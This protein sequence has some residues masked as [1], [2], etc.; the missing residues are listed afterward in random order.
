MLFIG[1]TLLGYISYSQLPVELLP[2]AEVPFLIVMV[3]STIDVDPDYLEKEAIIPLEGAVSTLEGIDEI[4]STIQSQRGTIYV[5][6]NQNVEIKY[7]YL[8]LQERV[9]EIKS[10]IS[11]EF[12][13]N[14]VK[15]D[16]ERLSNQFMTLQVRGSG[17]QERIRSIVDEK[18]SPELQSIDG[19]ANVEI[20]GGNV[21]ALEIILDE[22]A[23]SQYNITPARIRSLISQNTQSKTF[24]GW[25]GENDRRY[26]V[27]LLTEYTDVSNIEDI[28][29]VP[30]GPILL[31]DIA[32]INFG[33][34]EQESISRVNGM[35]AVSIS[36]VRDSQTNLIELSHTTVVRISELNERLA[37]Q[38]IEIVIQTN[39]AADV[40]ENINLIIELALIGGA[41]A[42]V[43]L[44]FFLRNLRLVLIMMLAIP[45]SVFT[46]FNFF[47][48][49][50][51]SLNSFTLVG[52][53]L[54]VG[55]LLDNSVVVLENIYRLVENRKDSDTAVIQGTREVWRAILAATLTTITVFLPFVF[56]TNYLVRLIGRHVGVSIISTLLVS[57]VVALLLVPM[58]THFFLK[59]RPRERSFKF[60]RISQRN[61]L[62]QIYTLLLKT[63]MR[64]PAQTIIG[65]VVAF[66]AS[67]LICMSLSMTVP[68]EIDL[69]EFNL[70]VTMS[71]GSTLEMT[72]TIVADFEEKISGIE[73][74]KDIVCTI[75]D[76][77]ANIT[78]ILKDDFESIANRTIAQIKNEI[79]EQAD[80][81]RAADISMSE[82]QSS[83]RFGGGMRSNPMAS[84]E[85][86]FG[87]GSPQEKVVVKGNDFGMIRTVAEDVKYYID[88]LESINNEAR[89]SISGNRPEIH[90]LFDNQLLSLYDISLNNIAAELS[91]F[92]RESTTNMKFKQGTE[93]YDIII[94]T[95]EPEEE[96]TFADLKE[97]P[98]PDRAGAPHVL[99]NVS[100]IIYSYGTSEITRINQ[101]KQVEVSF[102]FLEDITDS[103]TLLG[104]SREEVEDL[105]A[106]IALP[107]GVAVELVHDETEYNEFYYLIAA[108]FILIYMILASVFE[109]LSTPVVM[110]F[111]IP[112]AAIGA[113]WALIFTGNSIF[114]ANSLIGLLILLGVV[115]NNGIILIDYTRILRVR[116]LGRTRALMMA[117][118][119]RVRP[120]L[121]TTITTIFAML[122]LAMGNTE[123]I[124][125]IGAPFAIT[126]IG[127]LALSTLFT[128][129]FIPTVYSGMEMAIDWLRNL[130][131][132]MKL[133]QVFL[134][135][136]GGLLVYL[137]IE[138]VLWQFAYLFFLVM[139]VPGGTYFVMNSLR[140]AQS[141]VVGQ[142]K[143]LI[144]T[145]R[146][147]VKIYDNYSRFVR[148]WKKGER[149]ER[150]YGRV[151]D[152]RSWRDFAA[153][154]WQI[155]LL[156]FL[157]YFTYW[158]LESNFW[159]FVLSLVAYFY[160]FLLL[161]PI[162]R[163]LENRA[164]QT[165]R[166]IHRRDGQLLYHLIL[167][168]VP[169][170]NLWFFSTRNF[171]PGILAFIAIAWVATLG[172]YTI[173]N[174]L[175]AGRV[176]IMRLTGRLANLRKNIYRFVL[177]IPVIGRKKNPFNALDG[178]S[179]EIGSGM[180]GLLGPNGAGKTTI[181]RII[182]GI[183]NQ[184]MGTISINENDYRT[185]REE[186]Q[187]LIG[188]LPQEFGTYENMT[189]YEFLDYLAILKSIYD[190]EKRKNIVNYVLESVHLD[191]H[192]HQKINSF[193]GG[194]KQRVGIAL[195]L[196]HLPRILVV[197]EPTAGLDP[198]ERIR[199]R[200]LLVELSRDRIVIFSTHIIEDISSSCNK[201]AVLNRGALY[202]IGKPA[203]MIDSARGNVWQFVVSEQ[204]FGT[205]R[206]EIRIVHHMK[207]DKGIRIRCLAETKPHP[208]AITVNPTLEDAYLW[209][210][211]EVPQAVRAEDT[212]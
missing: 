7:A 103:K 148:E 47:Y 152:Y 26:V 133:L 155:P 99:E 123:Q 174:R 10:S 157:V 176:N 159:Q 101:E 80:N 198:R 106:S 36:L 27:N 171:K 194:M 113:F 11:E 111:T 203:K 33:Q 48:A 56:S 122:P 211:G 77:E 91:S 19:I 38:D 175:H 34:K 13:I 163:Y 130:S 191:D 85:R 5:Y 8:K 46:A 15:I 22:D 145:I 173:S 59:R 92:Q 177:F 105:I 21:R 134:F 96:K 182:C 97:L 4:E 67:I 192:K 40:E 68:S 32:D 168:G 29:V 55:M 180:F 12:R 144:I 71:R 132:K 114:N 51:I 158:Y 195:T 115:V 18:V 183:L 74:I 107:P 93:E 120:I 89:L 162:R 166:D 143:S 37:S 209:L 186:L 1:V 140:R 172:I 84:L 79:E 49:F 169:G 154:Q 20:V 76:E 83:R 58:A 54:A 190:S 95:N 204:E 39:T 6:Y 119:A 200:N 178:V 65:A 102:S 94:K 72:D 43:I 170:L 125:R 185:K 17:G 128:L 9:N 14:V 161:M 63:A 75:Y 199:F 64:Y 164:D 62:V 82:P 50:G 137:Y 52:I 142:E 61:R 141:D 117:G 35:E 189:A 31:K 104:E 24:L 139:A 45:I 160:V 184:T 116:G 208:E 87:I 3:N 181:M 53:A 30:E 23:Y 138:S 73:E 78:V 196:L 109:S 146:Q 69:T 112:L 212:V 16:T 210:L 135:I 188:Y 88:N 44:W 136:T 121:I 149:L 2:N 57:L 124:S 179:L 118:Q 131:W 28:I 193:S 100:R 156:G 129:V 25:A 66:F 60:H 110:M 150:L 147:T 81:F 70:Y 90:L 153:F 127:G 151:K 167:W 206:H 197:D 165:G 86:M 98:V 201:L 42:V 202:Y 207:F 205:L 108:A 187:G 126:V 41:L